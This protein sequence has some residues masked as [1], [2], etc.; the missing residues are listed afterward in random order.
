MSLFPRAILFSVL[1]MFALFAKQLPPDNPPYKNA[2][3]P[4]ETRVAD[5]L[6][7]MTLEE[8]ID[9]LG[10][11]GFATMP[12]VI[13]GPC[14]N[15]ARIPQGG[16][17]FES[18]GEDP[19]LTSIITVPYIK[20]V[21]SENVIATVKH[22]ACNNQEYQRDFV[23]VKI[24][25]RSL[26]EIYLPA[27]KAAVKDAD[28]WAFMCSYNRVNGHYASENDPLLIEKLKKE[29]GF[30]YLVMSDWGAVHSS[31]PV[32]K[33]GLDLEMPDGKYLNRK[34]LL[35]AIKSGIVAEDA[36][37]DKVKR[38]LRVIFKIGLFEN[39]GDAQPALLGTKENRSAAL[40]AGR[41]GIVLLQNKDNILPLD[42]NRL[43]SVAI[44]GPGAAKLRAGGGGSSQ[45]DPLTRVSPLEALKNEFGSTIKI[46]HAEGVKMLG[47]AMPIEEEVLYTDAELK[48]HGLKGE[49][50][51]NM[52]LKGKPA[53]TRVDKQ[54]NFDWGGESPQKPGAYVFETLS[55]DGQR[56]Y[57]DDKLVIND[58]NDHGFEGRT[59]KVSL[60]VKKKYKIVYEFYENGGSAAVRL[61][62]NTPAEKLITDAVKAA[63]ESDMAIIFAGT[64]SN[65]ESEGLD[66]ESLELPQ[67]QTELIQA[68]AKANKNT[69][70]VIT[71]GSP[72]L[73]DAWINDVKAVVETWFG[74]EMMG[75]AITDVLTGKYNPSGK[76]PVTFP[77]KW[78]D[79]SAFKTYKAMD[80]VT[81]YSDGIY[82]GYRHFEKNNIKPLFPFGFGLSY[83]TFEYA[84][85]KI[86]PATANGNVTVSFTI[87]NTGKTEGAEIAQLYL[88]D[89]KACV[90]RPH[91]ELKGFQKVVLKPGEKKPV[92]ISI[93]KNAMSFYHP[94]KKQWVAE[95]GEFNVL[96]GASSEDIKLSGSFNLK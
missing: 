58:W 6:T 5:L 63:S 55:D 67:G 14:V 37:N 30:T 19:F 59:A 32:A 77:R 34:T 16:R 12:N 50:Y 11:T 72:V 53:F 23:D 25:D 46:V 70:V 66:R 42:V 80:S 40:E 89:V 4:V 28:V 76:L 90:D 87:K 84:D 52:E 21:Q 39:P 20:G 83:T 56:L 57:I 13:L 81:Y 94:D 48:E 38:I 43:K 49:Y 3:L 18:F 61:A 54:V 62:W 47:D 29:W 95:P 69:I 9:I 26:N 71:S 93:D 44:I 74:G 78:E 79:C 31:I 91:K 60:E 65:I 68:V 41:A 36:I 64:T 1:C 2:G 86:A 88:H 92:T 85:L 10:G 73:M 22:F 24:D 75:H 27:F 96:I 82:V 35:D 8:K 45:V 7:R 15:I 17:N 33:G 51:S